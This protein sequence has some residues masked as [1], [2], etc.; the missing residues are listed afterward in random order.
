M[1]RLTRR[2]F[3]G[4][5]ATL[6]A[7][8]VAIPTSSA[9]AFGTTWRRRVGCL[10]A[11]SSAN[12]LLPAVMDAALLRQL[13]AAAL[14]AAR[15][16]GASY[17]DVRV[18]ELHQLNVRQ[19]YGNPLVP[20]VDLIVTFTYGVRVLADGVWAFAHGTAPDAT[21][22]AESARGAVATAK[23][24]ARAL[25]MPAQIDWTPAPAATG[26]WTTPI[27]ID[28]FGIPIEDQVALLWACEQAGMR[29]IGVQANGQFNWTRETRAIASTDGTLVTQ[30]TYRTVPYVGVT[31]ERGMGTVSLRLPMVSGSGG[32]ET[33]LLPQLQDHMKSASEEVMRWAGLAQRPLDVGR[34]SVVFDGFSTGSLASTTLGQALELD[35]VLGDEADAAGTSFLAPPEEILGQSLFSPMLNVMAGRAVPAV[36]AVKWDDEGVEVRPYPIITRG[37][38]VDYHTSRATAP[39]LRPWYERQRLPMT[40]RGCAVAATAANAVLIRTPHLTIAPGAQTASVDALCQEIGRGVLVHQADWGHL[41]MDPRCGSGALVR[42]SLFEIERGQIVRRVP[43]A[44]LQFSTRALWKSLATLGDASTVQTSDGWSMKGQ[45]WMTVRQ[46]ATA[47]AAAFKDVDLITMG[48]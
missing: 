14:D 44:V 16:A 7:A 4:A 38:V 46:S 22:V 26:E 24:N 47:P 2:K 40:S 41:T 23:G 36:A 28:P 39:V 27:T 12:A 5:A 21:A 30:T 34:Y 6:A 48:R 9:V 45:P 3:L 31:A 11:S 19:R 10:D 18:A 29:T 32:Y 1:T 20:D 8:R 42:A 25:K 35:R 17:A 33:V 37:T 15:S 43:D 13:A